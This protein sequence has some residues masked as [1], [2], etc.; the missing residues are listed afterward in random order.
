AHVVGLVENSDL[1]LAEVET[2]LVDEVLHATGGRDDDVDAA[3]E[4][5]DLL[6][7]RHAAHDRG[8]EE[9]DA[10]RD[11]L[12]RAVDLHRELTGGGEDERAGLAARLATLATVVLHETLDDGNTE[13]DRLARAGLAAAEHI[14]AREHVGDRRG[15]DRERGL[16][17]HRRELVRD[18]VADTEIAEGLALDLSRGHDLRLELLEHDVVMRGE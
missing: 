18:V 3:L 7:L 16:G 9:A 12:H 1:D 17:T 10:A 5:H 4:R 2:A 11:G 13:R 6:V 14:L 15:L 8:R